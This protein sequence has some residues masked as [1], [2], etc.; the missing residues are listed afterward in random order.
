ML[1][2][3]GLIEAQ[4]SDTQLRKL[5][6]DAVSA[7][8]AEKAPVCYFWSKSGVLMRKWRPSEVPADQEWRVLTQIVVPKSYRAE[9]LKLAHEP[10]TLDHLGVRKTQDR[11]LC[12]FFWPKLHQDV[13]EFCR[14]CHTCQ[15]VGKPNQ[16]NQVAPLITIPACGQPFDRVII[17]C[18]SPLPKTRSGHMYLLTIM[19]AST[20]YPE[21]IPLRNITAKSVSEALVKC[22]TRMGLPK[23]I[24]H[25]QGS[26]F[27]S[28]VFG[29]IMQLLGIEQNGFISLSSSITGCNRKIPSNLENDD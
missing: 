24:Q 26:N 20:R 17:D 7:Q 19:D 21:S 6:N 5:A 2:K 8:E 12:H 27:M 11:I 9:I 13:A 23:Q 25:D 22:F 15:V 3:N 1:N 28:K 4:E 14:T 29:E 10:P 18:V 16:K